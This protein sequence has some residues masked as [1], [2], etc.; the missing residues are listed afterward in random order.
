MDFSIKSPLSEQS[1]SS[2]LVPNKPTTT[3]TGGDGQT[4]AH[5]KDVTFAPFGRG[6]VFSQCTSINICRKPGKD[7]VPVLPNS[8]QTRAELEQGKQDM[9]EHF[10]NEKAKVD[11]PITQLR[12]AIKKGDEAVAAMDA[13]LKS[14]QD[15]G[16][17]VDPNEQHNMEMDKQ[18]VLKQKAG[19]E[20]DLRKFEATADQ[21]EKL[22]MAAKA[23]DILPPQQAGLHTLKDGATVHLP[24]H[25]QA[26]WAYISSDTTGH[27]KKP[28]KDVATDL[29]KA[30]L[31]PAHRVKM[32]ACHSA[33]YEPRKNFV[34]KPR[35]ADSG[36]WGTNAMAPA[37][38][39]AN[40]L[41]QPVTGYQGEGKTY[42]KATN[43]HFLRQSDSGELA[44]SSTVRRTFDPYKSVSEKFWNVFDV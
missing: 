43:E 6:D 22:L 7:F 21:V 28:L 23:T 10:S 5:L 42:A 18:N 15:Q 35:R 9:I 8:E 31:R 34:E 26:D 37:Q 20:S 29:K 32:P 14:W 1:G 17:P 2:P 25:G 24:G 39:L 19:F 44:Q 38:R 36:F 40:D 13:T 12:A 27:D 16:A 11:G 30:G 41:Q 33:D 4:L 3:A